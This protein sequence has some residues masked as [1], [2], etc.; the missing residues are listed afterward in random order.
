MHFLGDIRT[1][2]GSEMAGKGPTEQPC[3]TIAVF[4]YTTNEVKDQTGRSKILPQL[5]LS[6]AFL[7]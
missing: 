4:Y 1:T 7:L 2:G 6:R 5:R 3:A